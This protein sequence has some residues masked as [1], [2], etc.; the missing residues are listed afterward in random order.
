MLKKLTFFFLS[1]FLLYSY[2][3]FS[4]DFNIAVFIPGVV[5][6]N[7]IFE[8]VVKGVK[9]AHREFGFSFNIVEGGY[10]PGIWED[11]FRALVLAN[12]YNYILTVTE[13]M[14]EIIKKVLPLSKNV[15]FL[16]LDG[17]IENIK[18]AYGVKFKDKEMTY[19]C[20]LFSALVTTSSMQYANKL[21]KIGLIAGDVY[22]AMENELLPGYKEGAKS[23]DKDVDVIFS[24]VGSWNDPGKGK[25]IA[26]A[27][28]RQGVDIILNIAGASGIGI[29]EAAKEKK[30]Y[31]VCVDTNQNKKAPGIILGSA[32]KKINDV[33][34]ETLR[35]AISGKIPYGTTKFE[36][37]STGKI[38]FTIDDPYF[39]KYVPVD[40][41]QKMRE[42]IQK[43]KEGQIKIQ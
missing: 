5:G 9:K 36:G 4:S 40:I 1:I 18:N 43:I 41:Q 13:G 19:L 29:I 11:E 8:E 10:N 38:G 12:K 20:G 14:P 37:I 22:P 42:F 31:V 34:Y 28:Y 26:M 32:L 2:S 6:G 30:G 17:K 25:E 33:A 23:I 7:P 39:K 3:A 15:K 16:L 35:D 24:S 27:Q 21:K